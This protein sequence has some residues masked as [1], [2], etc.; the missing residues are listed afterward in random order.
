MET[1]KL[2]YEQEQE[3]NKLLT[4]AN[5]QRMRG[6]WV[7]AEDTCRKA[8]SINPRDVT[9]REMLGDILNDSGKLDMALSEYR[10][11]ME[12]APDR[13]SLEKKYAKVVLDI[14]ERE[15]EKALAQDMI[16]NPHKYTVRK[17]SAGMAFIWSALVP[18][19]GQFYN[20]EMVKALVV[21]GA[22]VLFFISYALL[23]GSYPPGVTD[24]WS[25]I[26]STNSAV[27]VFGIMALIAYIYGV[28]DAPIVAG[29]ADEAGRKHAEPQ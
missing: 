12:Q 16:E 20:G 5:V 22:T 24:I 3:V 10:T 28:I 27:L 14:A 21:F 17:R 8:L 2:T 4:L 23:Q 26:G 19:L 11:A 25:L 7:E 29:K 9:I 13:V 18:G 6:Q 15:R 1:E